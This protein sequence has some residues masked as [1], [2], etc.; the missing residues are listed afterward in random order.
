MYVV[1][2]ARLICDQN[3]HETEIATIQTWPG[4]KAVLEIAQST[5]FEAELKL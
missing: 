3:K 5:W 2:I 4:Y 1:L